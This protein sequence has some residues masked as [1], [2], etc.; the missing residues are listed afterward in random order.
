[1]GFGLS[2]GPAKCE[3]ALNRIGC[4]KRIFALWIHIWHCHTLLV[5]Y[6]HALDFW[7]EVWCREEFLRM[8]IVIQFLKFHSFFILKYGHTVRLFNL[9]NQ[10]HRVCGAKITH[11]KFI[12]HISKLIMYAHK[13]FCPHKVKNFA[14][15][16]IKL[17]VNFGHIKSTFCI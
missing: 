6:N 10:I 8:K 9:R 1:M 3:E 14:S 7:K 12:V 15:N 13:T 5:L 2:V 11:Q 16:S 4:G 17:Q